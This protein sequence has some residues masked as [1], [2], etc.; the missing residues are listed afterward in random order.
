M[1]AAM[2]PTIRHL[3]YARGY[4]DLGMVDEANDE[5]E[6]IAWDDRMKPEVLAMRVGLP[7]RIRHA[8]PIDYQ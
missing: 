5:L 4:I 6:A 3:Q 1:V 7:D 8:Y 2:V